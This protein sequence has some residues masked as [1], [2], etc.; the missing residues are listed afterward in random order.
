MP[1]WFKLFKISSR[2]SVVI[3]SP[4]KSV[5]KYIWLQIIYNRI[6][7]LWLNSELSCSFSYLN[8]SQVYKK[9][10]HLSK[11]KMFKSREFFLI[12]KRSVL[13]SEQTSYL[14]KKI[15]PFLIE[16]IKFYH[17]HFILKRIC[18]LRGTYNNKQINI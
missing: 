1:S 9:A 2:K 14:G 17:K 11:I 7:K 15:F 10:C 3:G 4:E 6:A 5:L 12:I 16:T 13:I 18:Y 8:I